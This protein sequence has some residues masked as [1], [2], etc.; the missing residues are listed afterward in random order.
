MDLRYIIPMLL[1]ALMAEAKM[2]MFNALDQI[3]ISED[4]PMMKGTCHSNKYVPGK[5]FCMEKCPP[6][7]IPH[8]ELVC[9]QEC[10]E[11]FQDL[12]NVCHH[13]GEI[14]RAKESSEITCPEGYTRRGTSYCQVKTQ[15]IPKKVYQRDYHPFYCPD[16]ARQL[17]R[18]VPR[19]NRVMCVD[20]TNDSYHPICRGKN[21]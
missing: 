14:I 21:Y 3:D 11:G 12:G 7:F 2:K 20:C 1:F 9:I 16:P 4:P 15:H 18:Y 8:D 17:L 19:L 13:T 10:P 5:S 6:G